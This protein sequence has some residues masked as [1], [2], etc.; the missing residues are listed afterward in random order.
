MRWCL[1]IL[2]IFLL[3]TFGVELCSAYG[4]GVVKDPSRL[5]CVL[6]DDDAELKQGGLREHSFTECDPL[7]LTGQN[8]MVRWIKA[9][10]SLSLTGAEILKTHFGV[11]RHRW[12]CRECC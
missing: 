4:C 12:L 2:S 11:R 5:V 10:L 3:L 9:D 8:M 1:H 6:D 7:S